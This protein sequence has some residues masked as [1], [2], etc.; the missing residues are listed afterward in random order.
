MSAATTHRPPYQCNGCGRHT[1]TR[2]FGGFCPRCAPLARWLAEPK[3]YPMP[4]N[5]FEQENEKPI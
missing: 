5:K 2:E 4:P 1:A 3:K